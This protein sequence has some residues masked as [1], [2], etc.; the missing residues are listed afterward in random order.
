MPLAQEPKHPTLRAVYWREEIVGLVLW[1]RGEG[2]DESLDPDV[3]GRFL[4]VDPDKAAE[5]LDRLAAQGYLQRRPD[6]RYELG[7]SGEEE[8]QRLIEGN[9]AVPPPTS[10]TCGPDC[11]CFTSPME[12]I[13]CNAG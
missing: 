5:H 11:W 3:L 4:G 7:E 9:R 6:G 1:L 8:G 2:W 12:A 10:G 13:Q